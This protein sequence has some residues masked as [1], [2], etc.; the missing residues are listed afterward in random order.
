LWAHRKQDGGPGSVP[1]RRS[2][3]F[4]VEEDLD[5]AIAAHTIAYDAVLVT[6]ILSN[7]ERV[8]GLLVEDWLG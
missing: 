3:A 8:P 7:F 2:R 5:V 4:A 6:N 1:L